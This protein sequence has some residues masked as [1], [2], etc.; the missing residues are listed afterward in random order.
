MRTASGITNGKGQYIAGVV[1]ITAGYSADG[2]YSHYLVVQS[3]IKLGSVSLA[4]GE[5]VFG[6]Q[7]MS[8]GE[9]LS[10]HLYEALTGKAVGTVEGHRLA[11]G[12]RVESLRIWPPGEKQVIQIGRFAI[13]YELGE[14]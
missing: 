3:P 7:S 11:A 5:Y 10:V 9:A 1:I 4:P 14:N 2:K 8:N 12:T 13:P 6:F